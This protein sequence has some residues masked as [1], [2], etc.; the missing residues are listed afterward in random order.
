MLSFT[1]I[2]AGLREH[3]CI[4]LRPSHSTFT[5]VRGVGEAES[6]LWTQSLPLPF[7]AGAGEGLPLPLGW[8]RWGYRGCGVV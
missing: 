1:I 2:K 6:H 7:L 4:L 5:S 8:R 3:A